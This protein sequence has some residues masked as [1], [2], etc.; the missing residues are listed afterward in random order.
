MFSLPSVQHAPRP[1]VYLRGVPRLLM[2]AILRF[3]YTGVANVTEE[4]VEAE[5]DS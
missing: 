4:E 5:E 2:R 1:V 3:L